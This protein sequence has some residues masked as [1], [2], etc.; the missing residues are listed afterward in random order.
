MGLSKESIISPEEPKPGIPLKKSTLAVIGVA[1]LVLGVA[2]SML[3]TSGPP[4]PNDLAQVQ[5]EAPATQVVGK[6]QSIDEEIKAAESL[7]SPVPESVKRKDNTAGLYEKQLSGLETEKVTPVVTPVRSPTQEDQQAVIEAE[8]EAQ[9]R[10]SKAVVVDFD[11]GSAAAA[12]MSATPAGQLVNGVRGLMQG[13]QPAR[14]PSEAAAPAFNAALD[15]L[16]GAAGQK[17]SRATWVKEYAGD[18][19][20]K[21]DGGKAL[22]SYQSPSNLV[23]HQGKVIPA[24]LGR[25]INS[26][27]P[28]KITA[29]TTVDIYDSLG[30]GQLLI[31]KGSALD[32]QY[33]SE[34]KVGQSRILFAFER[35]ILPD[36]TSFDLPP[37]QGSDLRGASGIA[38]DVNNHFFK[39][40]ASS[41]FIAFLAD[42]TKPPEG[43]T[44][45]G[46]SG[47]IT[48]AAGEVLVDVSK[49]ILDRN[50]VIPPTITVNQGERINVEVVSDMVFPHSYRSR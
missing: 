21:K 33:D 4:Q 38:G 19:E 24:V 5:K 8:R 40:F 34:V 45:I 18:L 36:G 43:A 6:T 37:A 23:L 17:V 15:Q 3:F 49:S 9:V 2:S 47:A 50:K 28:G 12:A 44:S 25:Q 29:Y 32:G 1:V 35:L 27:L 20:G 13:D 39:M 14:A 30:K 48:G 26:D 41:F 31:P 16:R 7:P 11:D 10:L 22:H 46:G 42:K